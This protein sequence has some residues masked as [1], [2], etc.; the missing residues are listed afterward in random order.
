MRRVVTGHTADGRS[1][2]VRDEEAPNGVAMEGVP[3]FRVDPVWESTVPPRL[4]AAGGDP[5]AAK[6]PFFP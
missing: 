6:T 5:T 2:F 1:V 3:R 4:S